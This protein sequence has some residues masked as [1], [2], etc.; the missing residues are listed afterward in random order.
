MSRIA[1]ITGASSGIG[2]STAAIFAK[3]G[4]NLVITG[5]RKAKLE[6]L[7][8]K[9]RSKYAIQVKF[10]VFDIRNKKEVKK[11]WQSLKSKWTH[12]DIL[13]NNAGLAKGFDPIHKGHFIHWD[14]MIDTNIKGLL[15]I[16]RLV[17][18]QMV[19]RGKGHIINVASTAGKEVYPSGNVYCASKHAVDALTKAMRIDLYKH[20]IRVGQVAPGHV[21]STEFAL[22]R[23]D[24]D[25]ERAR[26]YDDFVPL[27]S[28]DVAKIIYFMASQP[29]HVNIQDILVLGSQQASNIFIDRSG[30]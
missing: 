27:N 24:G 2:K 1:F 12:I 18:E 28:K 30:R 10:L 26:I 21:E 23:F 7:A 3:H 20:G 4:Y 5:R 19:E 8:N 11:A 29:K 6:E 22:V 15:Y 14:Q 9:L 25:E 17:S 13:I 16:T